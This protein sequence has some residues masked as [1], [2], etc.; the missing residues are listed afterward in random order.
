MTETTRGLSSLSGQSEA[1][2]LSLDYFEWFVASAAVSCIFQGD[3]IVSAVFSWQIR[4]Q[5][6]HWENVLHPRRCANQTLSLRASILWSSM[7]FLNHWAV[8][9]QVSQTLGNQYLVS[10]I[11][12]GYQGDSTG[13]RVPANTLVFPTSKL[14]T[15]NL[16]RDSNIDCWSLS[17]MLHACE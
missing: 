6:A 10:H 5:I 1:I 7:E 16:L 11:W 13:S 2:V 14:V 15:H 3:Q 9:W 17:V 12:I 4:L 8:E